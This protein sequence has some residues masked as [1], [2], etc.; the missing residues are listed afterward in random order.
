M[1]SFRILGK[2]VHL[3]QFRLRGTESNIEAKVIACDR[4]LAAQHRLTPESRACQQRVERLA[5]YIVGSWVVQVLLEDFVTATNDEIKKAYEENAHVYKRPARAT[6]YH[7]FVEIPPDS[8]QEKDAQAREKMSTAFQEYEKTADF[9]EVCKKYSEDPASKPEFLIKDIPQGKIEPA[10][11]KA[12]FALEKDGVSEIVK[13]RTGLHVFQLTEKTPESITPLDE[14]KENVARGIRKKK[15]FERWEQMIAGA[16]EEALREFAKTID[17]ASPGLEF[18][19]HG[20]KFYSKDIILLNVVLAG[21]AIFR[22]DLSK[23][24]LLRLNDALFACKDQTF[25]DLLEMP[26][27]GNTVKL[28]TDWYLGW[29]YCM[30][31]LRSEG[32]P[33]EEQLQEFYTAK[34]TSYMTKPSRKASMI[35]LPVPSES[36]PTKKH[37][38][39][40]EALKIAEDIVKE[41]RGG[42]DF[43]A[44]ARKHSKDPSAENGGYLGWLEEPSFYEA[45]TTLSKMKPGEISD[46]MKSNRGYF[47]FQLYEVREPLPIP[48]EEV[49]EKVLSDVIVSRELDTW[50]AM[51]LEA[52]KEI[53]LK[54]V[55]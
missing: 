45:D 39:F 41:A 24:V 42:G 11:D 48:F 10:L 9:A 34:L 43:A 32:P 44:L 37:Y 12:I 51:L 7:L 25:Q 15:A 46:P 18:E 33:T 16:S 40:S 8:T 55:K 2:N 3:R 31:T 35:V 50:D 27:Y 30:E 4:V 20:E 53:G 1:E 13:T 54:K 17:L 23:T 29:Q 19:L 26:L 22:K 6:V 5:P 38:A 49:R 52:E 14:V 21:E 28:V 47:I 36:D